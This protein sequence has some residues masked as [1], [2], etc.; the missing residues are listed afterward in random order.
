MKFFD[1]KNEETVIAGRI[2]ELCAARS[3]GHARPAVACCPDIMIA[4][5]VAIGAQTVKLEDI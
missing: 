1:E 4:A 5:L 3:G 2:R